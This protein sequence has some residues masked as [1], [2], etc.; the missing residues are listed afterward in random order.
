MIKFENKKKKAALFDSEILLLQLCIKLSLSR[1]TYSTKIFYCLHFVLT[2]LHFMKPNV[3]NKSFTFEAQFTVE[4]LLSKSASFKLYY[5]GQ[6]IK[7]L[8]AFIKSLKA[9]RN[10]EYLPR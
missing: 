6:T 1:D 7:E 5:Y 2:I 9:G 4:G 8:I 10:R 3:D